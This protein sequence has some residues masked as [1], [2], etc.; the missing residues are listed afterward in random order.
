[1]FPTRIPDENPSLNFTLRKTHFISMLWSYRSILKSNWTEI[2]ILTVVNICSIII[3]ESLLQGLKCSLWCHAIGLVSPLRFVQKI[4][5]APHS[6]MCIQLSKPSKND[7]NIHAFLNCI[8]K[9]FF[10]LLNMITFNSS[11]S[12]IIYL[13]KVLFPVKEPNLISPKGGAKPSIK[14]ASS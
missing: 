3:D 7:I 2:M 4:C 13:I 12:T 10:V 1:M 14:S 6:K 8:F 9:F 11:V 5:S